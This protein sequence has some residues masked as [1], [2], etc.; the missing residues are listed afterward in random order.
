M[1]ERAASA[2]EDVAENDE[3]LAAE[4]EHTVERQRHDSRREA[5]A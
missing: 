1:G 2:P 3:G 4:E 5:R